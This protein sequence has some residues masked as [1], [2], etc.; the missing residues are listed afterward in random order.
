MPPKIVV[1]EAGW[2]NDLPPGGRLIADW[3]EKILIPDCQWLLPGNPR[4]FDLFQP[5]K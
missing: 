2:G 4:F 1:A 3:H 5:V